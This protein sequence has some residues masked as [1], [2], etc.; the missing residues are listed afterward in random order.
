MAR[1]LALEETLGPTVAMMPLVSLLLETLVCCSGCD[2]EKN[3]G[4][5]QVIS[6]FFQ[7]AFSSCTPFKEIMQVTPFT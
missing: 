5:I 4:S 6:V 3:K 7:S 1:F 2:A